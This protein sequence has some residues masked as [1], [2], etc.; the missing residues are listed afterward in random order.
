M[1]IKIGPS[2]DCGKVK[3]DVLALTICADDDL[4]KADIAMLQPY[5]ALRYLMPDEQKRFRQE[6]VDFQTLIR[7]QCNIPKKADVTQDL[8]A[9][10]KPCVLGAYQRQRGEWMSQLQG[11][12]SAEAMQEVLRSPQEH[13]AFQAWLQAKGF[14]GSDAVIDGAYGGG[15]RAAI[16]QMQAQQGL[17]VDGWAS[18]GMVVAATGNWPTPTG[19]RQTASSANIIP[20]QSEQAQPNFSQRTEPSTTIANPSPPAE[21]TSAD[22]KR[23]VDTERSNQVRFARDFKG[24]SFED[25][26]ALKRISENIVKD[27]YVVNFGTSAFGGGVD[28]RLTKSEVPSDM[29]DWNK[30][31]Q[32]IVRGVISDTSLGDVVLTHCSFGERTAP[33]SNSISTRP[34]PDDNKW[35]VFNRIKRECE[36]SEQ[37][38]AGIIR[39]LDTARIRHEEVDE[40]REGGIVVQVTVEMPSDNMFAS[41]KQ[42]TYYRGQFRCKKNNAGDQQER[43]KKLQSYE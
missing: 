38:P 3:D 16:K 1:P 13:V 31:D 37:G 4:R 33:V 17:A 21:F 27:G 42:A 35:Y 15:T 26:L 7:T 19:E 22:I 28:C 12:A 30:G 20:Q 8:V 40:I 32:K 39:L 36:L 2:Y 29:V 43:S 23:I 11:R 25:R 10:L 34:S 5:F 41:G 24:R 14:L 9:Q 6:A 18:N